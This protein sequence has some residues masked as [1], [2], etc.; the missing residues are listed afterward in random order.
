MGI[1]GLLKGINPV[2]Q[3]PNGGKKSTKECNISQFSQQSLAVDV[4][5][6]MHKAGYAIADTLV[7]AV[8]KQ[9]SEQHK[10]KEGDDH[11]HCCFDFDW[12]QK[13]PKIVSS[14]VHH[15]KQR[16]MDLFRYAHVRTIYLVLDGPKRIPLKADTAQQRTSKREDHL[17]KARA[18]MRQGRRDKASEEYRCCVKVP[19]ELAKLVTQSLADNNSSSSIKVVLAPYEADS[20]LTQLALEGHV[21]GVI[22][23][24]SDLLVYSAAVG[25]PFDIITK[26]N[27]HTGGCEVVNIKWLLPSSAAGTS[28]N[29]K[30]A[31]SSVASATTGGKKKRGGAAI[32]TYL[33]L[34]QQQEKSS[35]GYGRRL[36][37][38][39][40]VLAGC[41][42]VSSLDGIG[43]I[44]A[45][46]YIAK[47]AH[48]RH[49]DR[50]KFVLR[51]WRG[52]NASTTSANAVDLEAYEHKLIQ[53]ESVFYHQ[54]ARKSVDNPSQPP[55]L[56]HQPRHVPIHVVHLT[57]FANSNMKDGDEGSTSTSNTNIIKMEGH[58]NMPDMSYFKEGELDFL[59]TDDPAAHVSRNTVTNGLFASSNA[60]SSIPKNTWFQAKAKPTAV[61]LHSVTATS[62]NISISSIAVARKPLGSLYNRP[63]TK[64]M[65][66][67]TTVS[68]SSKNPYRSTSTKTSTLDAKGKENE[69][70][71]NSS[72][73][74]VI[75]TL[76]KSDDTNAPDGNANSLFRTTHGTAKKQ[77][78]S[79]ALT[80]FLSQ[81]TSSK[82]QLQLSGSKRSRQPSVTIKQLQHQT[83][84]SGRS[85]ISKGASTFATSS[86]LPTSTTKKSNPFA[87]FNHGSTKEMAQP[88]IQNQTKNRTCTTS[89][90]ETDT[91]TQ[92]SE[93]D[94]E[95]PSSY[96]EHMCH[97]EQVDGDKD[98][99]ADEDEDDA[100]VVPSSYPNELAIY[101]LPALD[102]TSTSTGDADK[103]SGQGRPCLTN[104]NTTDSQDEDEEDEVPSSYPAERFS[105][106]PVIRLSSQATTTMTTTN[107]TIH[108][109]NS[110]QSQSQ[111]EEVAASRTSTSSHHFSSPNERRSISRQQPTTPVSPSL[112][113]SA[114]ETKEQDYIVSS[115]SSY[116]T[117]RRNKRTKAQSGH[118]STTD[119]KN[120]RN[121]SKNVP[122]TQVISLEIENVNVNTGSG[123]SPMMDLTSPN[124][125]TGFN[126]AAPPQNSPSPYDNEK[127]SQPERSSSCHA[128]ATKLSTSAFSPSK[129]DEKRQDDDSIQ[130]MSPEKDMLT[131][132]DMLSSSQVASLASEPDNNNLVCVSSPPSFNYSAPP[133][134]ETPKPQTSPTESTIS[135]RSQADQE[136]DRYND[137]DDEV[138]F[139][140]TQQ[141]SK[142]KS[143]F[144]TKHAASFRTTQVNTTT[145]STNNSYSNKKRRVMPK[146][147]PKQTKLTSFIK[148]RPLLAAAAKNQKP[149]PKRPLRKANK[150]NGFIETR[151]NR[152]AD[153]F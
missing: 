152:L 19:H 96:P 42:Y 110:A 75:V 12:K 35:K 71:W 48:R 102:N 139:L 146:P 9:Q 147:I 129:V 46:K 68:T 78:S 148:R 125:N 60:T 63:Q 105:I 133:A 127:G 10:S 65:Q 53:S 54:F 120:S 89:T 135:S 137:D 17:D 94:E 104:T 81:S 86:S 33:Q 113:A 130:S 28:D 36:F 140:G 34:F 108:P 56:I 100:S 11:N 27:R 13:H 30:K 84:A 40:C 50:F 143:L 118:Q 142:R 2:F 111:D 61:N 16:C 59:G 26:L 70:Q 90:Q 83:S 98:D 69:K 117:S 114:S 39:S 6:W 45:C 49:A 101:H 95:V 64:V 97:I 18:F 37:V 106:L 150:N 23:E 74:D 8:E 25:V 55:L 126:Y 29:T 51:D 134:C 5:S 145:T 119:G 121:R 47:H 32:M 7:E 41:D 92:S 131:A 21:T 57:P 88:S 112:S 87:K 62:T 67:T 58:E 31:L 107:M 1:N 128:T 3:C 151:R 109:S 138:I 82:P 132:K 14:L 103:S 44:T 153:D 122:A 52:S 4:S 22:T 116:F 66:R 91:C 136:E 43:F 24:D 124:N 72:E 20:Q 77:S 15:I 144:G 141:T 76:S 38:Q 99:A 79:T 80:D 73:D 123:L 85:I 115:E 93:E 149:P